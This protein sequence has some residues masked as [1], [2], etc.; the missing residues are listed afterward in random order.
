MPTKNS[1]KRGQ[2]YDE[3]IQTIG[4]YVVYFSSFSVPYK[5]S[6]FFDTRSVENLSIDLD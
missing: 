4:F 2:S 5:P 3:L 6:T 1:L